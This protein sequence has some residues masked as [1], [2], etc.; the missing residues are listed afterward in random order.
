M[1]ESVPK[2]YEHLVSRKAIQFYYKMCRE[3]MTEYPGLEIVHVESHD[4]AMVSIKL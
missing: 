3:I 1:K 2:G 4:G